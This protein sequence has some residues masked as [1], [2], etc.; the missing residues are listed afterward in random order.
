ME[1][2]YNL[3]FYIFFKIFDI[4]WSFISI[5]I[6][7]NPPS[8]LK[9]CCA[10]IIIESVGSCIFFFS[11]QVL[12]SKNYELALVFTSEPFTCANC[13]FK[14]DFNEFFSIKN[15]KKLSKDN[16]FKFKMLV[17]PKK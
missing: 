3:H 14:F 4:L 1:L 8:I 16:N 11:S 12:L 7:F 6:G 10:L 2:F 15:F 5:S 17:F 9:F 13:N